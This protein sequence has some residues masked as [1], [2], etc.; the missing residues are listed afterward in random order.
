MNHSIDYVQDCFLVFDK[1]GDSRIDKKQVGDLVRALGL[2]P[3]NNDVNRVTKNYNVRI[4]FEEFM[5]I[6]QA[7]EKAETEKE[8][9]VSSFYEGFKVFDVENQGSM[10]EAELKD[11][12][13]RL[14]E[15]LSEDEANAILAQVVDSDGRVSVDKLIRYVTNP[16]P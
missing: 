1:V 16:T 4:T 5:P 12:L 2:N 7:L 14:G 6:Y 8:Y 15:K 13:T 10:K 9:D 11:L 3:T